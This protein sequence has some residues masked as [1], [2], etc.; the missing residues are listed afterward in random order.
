LLNGIQGIENKMGTHL[1]SQG[2]KTGFCQIPVQG[3]Q[4]DLFGI[5][6]LFIFP[7]VFFADLHKD[8]QHNCCNSDTYP[9]EQ[10]RL[11]KGFGN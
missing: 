8:E 10:R 5:D 7:D 9:D 6:L 4:F 2:N 3:N 1:T 11:P